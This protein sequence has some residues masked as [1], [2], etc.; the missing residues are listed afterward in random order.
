MGGVRVILGG[1][2]RGLGEGLGVWGIGGGGWGSHRSRLISQGGDAAAQQ[3]EGEGNRGQ[4]PPTP[5][6]PHRV[7]PRPP[8]EP[9][10]PPQTPPS[11]T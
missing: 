1:A 7:A 9:S 4:C 10:T 6:Q 11:P 8:T 2:W 5:P 3:T